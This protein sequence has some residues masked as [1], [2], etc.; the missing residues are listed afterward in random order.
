MRP[1]KVDFCNDI[2]T[3]ARYFGIERLELVC[4]H[5]TLLQR[6]GKHK[7]QYNLY[8]GPARLSFKD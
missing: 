8:I 1:V 7:L 6:K 2:E 3:I 5:V 4:E